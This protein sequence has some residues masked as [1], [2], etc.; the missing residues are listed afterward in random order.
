MGKRGTRRAC[1]LGFGEVDGKVEGPG[2]SALS[3]PGMRLELH[4]QRARGT[5]QAACGQASVVVS[6]GTRTTR[7]VCQPAS[8]L[9]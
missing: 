7:P 9:G 1:R 4:C 5:S 3:V 8:C 6:A 2:C